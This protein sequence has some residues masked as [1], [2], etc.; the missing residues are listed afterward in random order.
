MIILF[1]LPVVS[2]WWFD[3]IIAPMLRGLHGSAELHVIVAPLWRNTGIDG[4][5]LQPL[6]DLDGINWHV[7][8]ADDPADFRIDAGHVEG[9][10]ELVESIAPD[11]TLAR[12]AD[13]ITPTRFPGTLRYIME[14]AASPFVTDPTWIVLEE[15]PFCHGVMPVGIDAMAD[16]AARV[17]EATWCIAQAE[18]EAARIDGP[19]ILDLAHDRP[20]VAVPLQYEHEENFFLA[21]A[22][23]PDSIALL[24]HLFAS[25][26]PG[27]M[28]A[29]TDHPLNRLHINRSAVH[30]LIEENEDRAVLLTDPKA[31]AILSAYADAM[32]VDLSKSWSAAAFC[33]LPMVIPGDIPVADW[34]HA[35]HEIAGIGPLLKAGK[36]SRPDTAEARRWFGWHFGTR[37]IDP[38]SLTLDMLLA[39]IDGTADDA[40]IAANIGALLS[41]QAAPA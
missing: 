23:Y 39:R 18:M 4:E 28:L 31:T 6:A 27:V 36:L 14:G 3:R 37:I 21:H 10:I 24:R 35:R 30:R 11:I 41:L 20:I 22:A 40:T 38:A 25:I 26:D 33:G 2:P 19:V 1:Y 8:D 34:L 16:R 17:M 12:S 29:I 13:F 32:V 9:L 5:Q 15:Q 7:V